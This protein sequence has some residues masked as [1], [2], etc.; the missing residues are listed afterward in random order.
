MVSLFIT[1]TISG[2]DFGGNAASVNLA[3]QAGKT[4]SV[5]LAATQGHAVPSSDLLALRVHV[6]A[7][8]LVVILARIASVLSPPFRW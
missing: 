7:I 8:L 2:C 1:C 4:Q 6:N 3:F 5:K